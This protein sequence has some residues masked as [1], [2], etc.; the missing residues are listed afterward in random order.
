MATL[1]PNHSITFHSDEEGNLVAQINGVQGKSCEGLLDIL[2]ALG[3]TLSEDDTP[4]HDRPEPVVRGRTAR[5][6][7]K[8]Q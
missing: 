2:Q 7:A 4:D 1:P 6:R 5:N 3:I 8:T